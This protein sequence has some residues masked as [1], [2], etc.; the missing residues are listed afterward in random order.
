MPHQ[1]EGQVYLFLMN[2]TD[3]DSELSAANPWWRT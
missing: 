3:I 1:T 2:S